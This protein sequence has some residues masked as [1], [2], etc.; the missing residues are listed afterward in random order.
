MTKHETVSV[1]IGTVQSSNSG[2]VQD[3]T[4]TVEFQAETLGNLRT[5]GDGRDGN[6]TDT[7]GTDETLYRTDDGRL[8]VH[9]EDWSQWQG[10]P[11]IYTLHEVTEADLQPNGRFEALGAEAGY[12][13]PLTLDE[14]LT[15]RDDDRADLDRY[16]AEMRDLGAS[17]HDARR[18]PNWERSPDA[19]KPRRDSPL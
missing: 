1:Q 10:E 15:R 19:G 17:K 8:V 16:L 4:K 3:S 7:R 12:G 2:I 13:R 6:P 18:N 11:S 5:Y 14:A 9:V